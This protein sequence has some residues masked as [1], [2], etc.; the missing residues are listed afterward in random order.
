MFRLKKIVLLFVSLIFCIF[1]NSLIAEKFTTIESFSPEGEVREIKQVVVQFSEP[2]VPFGSP[3]VKNELFDINCPVQGKSRWL[4]EKT[5][6]YEFEKNLEAATK[7]V[8]TLKDSARTL[9]GKSFLGK[10]TFEMNTGGPSI[11]QTEPYEGSFIEESQY[12]YLQL[13]AEVNLKSLLENLYFTIDGEREKIY[14]EKVTGKEEEGIFSTLFRG[15][16]PKNSLI[17]KPRLTFPPGKKISLVYGKGILSA[18]GIPTSR[19]QVLGFESRE[20]FQ[21][22]VN[23]SRENAKSGCVPLLDISLNFNS[24]VSLEFIKKIRIRGEAFEREPSLK[25]EDGSET[26]LL[27]YV[28]FKAPFPENTTLFLD[29]PK[30]ITDDAGRKLTGNKK[31]IKIFVSRFPPLAKFPAKFGILEWE[32][33]TNLPV[34]IRNIDPGLRARSLTL[35]PNPVASNGLPGRRMKLSPDQVLTYLHKIQYQENSKSIFDNPKLTFPF[36]VPQPLGPST[37]QSVGIPIKEPGFHIVEIESPYLGKSLLETKGSMY[38]P[39]TVL[40]TGMG[41]HFKMGRENSLVWVTSLKTAKPVANASISVRNCK[42]QQVATGKTD[43]NGLLVLKLP[44]PTNCSYYTYQNGF[45]VIAEKENDLSFVHSSWNE[46]IESWRYNLPGQRY[47][48]MGPKIMH[49]ILDRTLFRAGETVS[50]KHIVRIHDISGL[51]IPGAET[52]PSKVNVVHFGTNQKYP[53]SLKWSNSGTAES[54]WSIPKEAKLGEYGLEFEEAQG[55][56]IS[57]STTFRIEEFRLPV[58]KGFIK[59]PDEKL[60]LQNKVPIQLQVDYLSGGPAS[61]LD[62]QFKYFLR[63]YFLNPFKGY[64]QYE[65]F[66][67]EVSPGQIRRPGY[68]YYLADQIVDEEEQSGTSISYKKQ[69]VRMDRNGAASVFIENLEKRNSPLSYIL[70]ME[71]RDPNGEVQ[72]ISSNLPI[73]PSNL[74]V[75]MKRG[76]WISNG[77]KVRAEMVVLD[78]AGKPVSNTNIKVKIYDKKT[79][80]NRKRLVGGFYSYDELEEIRELGNFCSGNTDEK[81]ML[82]CEKKLEEKV[83]STSKL[84]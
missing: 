40:V 41:V 4:D 46:G 69:A 13:A 29:L 1:N 31:P 39:T 42:N 62:V 66:S 56:S 30:N 10:K 36:E 14:A 73:F 43:S 67:G 37:F 54:T 3:G 15:K 45:L 12:F 60:V 74:A 9:A 17:I 58:L 72:T 7:C 81:G 57:G 24:N 2:M 50:M 20:P 23:C 48:G 70:E 75:G 16:V 52:L 83:E 71:Y 11:V 51:S 26:G 27:S 77:E 55:K 53:L 44:E 61:F 79:Y 38:I 47:F 19:D 80:T 21:V 25:E 28:T 68:N 63:E 18:S 35:S 59:I 84:P 34:A 65:F 22:T 6:V 78:L 76:D 82:I 32:S 64:E 8:F 33:E 5:Y 49:T